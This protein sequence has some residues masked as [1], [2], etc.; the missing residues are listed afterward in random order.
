M[1]SLNQIAKW[2]EKK[3]NKQKI[4]AWNLSALIKSSGGSQICT[5][6]L[7]ETGEKSISYLPHTSFFFYC[8]ANCSQLA[9]EEVV[10]SPWWVDKTLKTLWQGEVMAPYAKEQKTQW[11]RSGR[12]SRVYNWE[13]ETQTSLLAHR[14]NVTP[15]ILGLWEAINPIRF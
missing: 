2:K 9:E 7:R 8:R 5:S 11:S 13:Y 1:L 15:P 3:Q 6:V 12:D 10:Y 4:H 14:S